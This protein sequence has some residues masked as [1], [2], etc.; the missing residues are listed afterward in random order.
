MALKDV[1]VKLVVEGVANFKSQMQ[2]AQTTMG[3]LQTSFK[4]HQRAIGMAAAA[5]G[6]AI[7]GFG[8]I[9]VKTY[10]EAGDEVAKLAIK[11]GFS[12][13]ALSELRHAAEL[14]GT[15]LLGIERASKTL[16]GAIT[17]AGYG[18]ETYVRAFDSIGL[19]YEQLKELNPEEQFLTVLEAIT[20]L[21]DDTLKAA[22]AAD[23][24]GARMGTALLPIMDQG[25]DYLN[26]MREEAHKLNVVFT[27]EDA[28]AAV[29]MKDAITSLTTS[30]KGLMIVIAEPLLKILTPLAKKI[31]DV[32]SSIGKWLD[33]HKTLKTVVVIASMALGGLLL[34]LG[35]LLLLLPALAAAMTIGAAGMATI[36][37]AVGVVTTAITALIAIGYVLWKHWDTITDALKVAW[38]GLAEAAKVS[39]KAVATYIITPLKLVLETVKAVV[40]AVK[41]IPLI[42]DKIPGIGTVSNTLDTALG[43][44][45]DYTYYSSP[46]KSSGSTVQNNTY[47]ITENYARPE[48]PQ[49]VGLTLQSLKMYTGS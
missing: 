22:T 49:N 5:A 30:I 28:A 44:I 38:E 1:G 45:G 14:S 11:T 17:D 48:Q 40:D 16:S 41:S 29:E 32:V 6:T 20:A 25:I 12:T 24:F 13:E 46:A 39:F 2:S 7:L 23:L 3:K 26:E 21:E 31:T 15:S 10:Y 18:L 34:V 8:A 27:E 43:K 33:K 47:N 4:Q 36:G 37:F 9:A 35:S 42:G 19:S